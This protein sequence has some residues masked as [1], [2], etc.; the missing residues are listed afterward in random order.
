M[1][2]GRDGSS[3][4]FAELFDR[5]RPAIWGFYR[6]RVWD[7]ER[8]ED[9]VQETFVALI[10]SAPRYEPRAPFRSFLFGIAFNLLAEERRKPRPV[11]SPDEL[12]GLVAASANQDV[13]LHVRQAIASLDQIDRDVLLLREFETLSYADIAATL[14]IPL[15]T[16]RSR[17]FRARMAVR[18]KL[19]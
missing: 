16:V 11:T 15:N 3:D 6:R 5:Y 19:Q 12:P 2:S 7:R 1:A 18:E 14:E 4:A 13:V 9:L 17:L 10:K 8:A